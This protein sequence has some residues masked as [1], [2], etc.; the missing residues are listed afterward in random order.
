LLAP[1]AC[2]MFSYHL[3]EIPALKLKHRFEALPKAGSTLD[4]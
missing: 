4:A 3:V 1:F 2:A